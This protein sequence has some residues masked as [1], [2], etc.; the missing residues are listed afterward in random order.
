LSYEVAALVSRWDRIGSS[1]FGATAYEE[2]CCTF[3]EGRVRRHGDRIRSD[4]SRHCASDHRRCAECWHQ[5]FQQLRYDL[6]RLEISP[7][8]LNTA[9]APSYSGP[10][11]FRYERLV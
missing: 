2:P 7:F 8:N 5:A 10:F 6:D 9:R 3:C 11:S 4:C 1:V